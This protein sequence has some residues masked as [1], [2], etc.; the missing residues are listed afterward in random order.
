MIENNMIDHEV[1][2]LKVLSFVTIISA[3]SLYPYLWEGAFYHLTAVCFV[4]MTRIIWKLTFGKWSLVS[5]VMH[6]TAINNLLDEIFFDPKIISYNEY[7]TLLMTVLI[8]IHNKNKW[9]R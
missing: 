2:I 5:L 1:K 8:I 9:A 3:Y 6:V 7:F 4:A